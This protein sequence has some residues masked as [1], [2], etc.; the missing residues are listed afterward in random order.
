MKLISVCLIVALHFSVVAQN[1]NK[2][3]SDFY[4]IKLQPSY[5]ISSARYFSISNVSMFSESNPINFEIIANNYSLSNENNYNISGANF[6]Y[7]ISAIRYFKIGVKHKA[8]AIQENNVVLDNSLNLPTTNLINKNTFALI[9]GNEDYKSYQT[10]LSFE[11]NVEFAQSDAELFKEVCNK[12]LGIPAD[13]IIYLENAG[14]VKIKQSISQIEMICKHS[15]HKP[16]IIL[17]YSGHGLP[18]D[19]TKIPYLIPVD[20]SG[21]SLDYAI[22]LSELYKSLTKYPTKKVIVILDACFTGEARN[23]G[24]VA[25]RGVKV[26]PKKQELA[27]NLII[28]SASSSNQPAKA[29]KEKKHGLFTYFLTKKL[30]QTKG[31]V[32]LGELEKY[33][34]E[35]VPLKSILINKTEQVP[36][37]NVSPTIQSEWK[38]WNIY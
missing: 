25:S 28:F 6:F 17:Y 12:T 30:I 18:N 5:C 4:S 14:Y 7:G 19:Q 2:S 11:Q 27:G 16:S 3:N 13:N 34:I 1:N 9:I 37:I 23:A 32:K 33:L 26:K 38:N 31:N 20:V 22:S 35:K 21:T 24:L 29:F 15:P 36:Q 10:N 8:T